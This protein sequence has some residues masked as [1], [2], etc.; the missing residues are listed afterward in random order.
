MSELSLVAQPLL[1]WFDV[2]PGQAG[3][4]EQGRACCRW[5]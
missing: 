3:R 4:D 2:W 5:R 1:D